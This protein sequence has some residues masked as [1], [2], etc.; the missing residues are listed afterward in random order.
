MGSQPTAGQGDCRLQRSLKRDRGLVKR[1]S[2]F[3]VEEIEQ[4]K[5]MLQFREPKNCKASAILRLGAWAGLCETW[6]ANPGIS[7]LWQV[8]VFGG[9]YICR[10]CFA[11]R[12]SEQQDKKQKMSKCFPGPPDGSHIART[13]RV[14][15]AEVFDSLQLE[16]A[17]VAQGRSSWDVPMKSWATTCGCLAGI[18]R[19]RCYNPK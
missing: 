13:C 2:Q 15:D 6:H 19:R 9:P 12:A 18:P 10:G 3:K 5:W 17:S 7:F 1:A 4:L 11:V 14:T 8:E 16:R